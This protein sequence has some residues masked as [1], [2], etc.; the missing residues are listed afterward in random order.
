MGES[1]C[2]RGRSMGGRRRLV[3]RGEEGREEW[4]KRVQELE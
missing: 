1:C 4:S 2:S 3:G